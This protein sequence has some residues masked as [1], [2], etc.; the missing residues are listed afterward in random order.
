MR[1][2]LRVY[3][4]GLARSAS[5]DART[6]EVTLRLSDGTVSPLAL[7]RWLGPAD[8][9]DRHLLSTI[10][11]PVLDV[12]CGPGRHLHALAK[13]GVFALGIDLSPV[14]VEL[15]RDRGGN[16][17]VGSI[18][19][20]V[21]G[22]GTWRTALLLD[23]NI[24]IG[25]APVQLLTRVRALLSPAGALL[26]ELD[27][28]GADTGSLVA[29]I[30]RAAEVSSWFR[31]A[32]VAFGDIKPIAEAAGYSL[33]QRAHLGSRWFAR[34]GPVRAS[35]LA[36]AWDASAAQ[37]GHCNREDQPASVEKLLNEARGP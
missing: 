6:D 32:R 35:G 25:G 4:D 3:G 10:A 7:G 24:G 20:H 36:R 23:G 9:T 17:I 26:V 2:P 15:A 14:A 5:P 8:E 1:S 31:W 16:A 30:E 12:G 33:L 11:G 22:A 37:A 27:P 13:R 19:D 21:P 18:F 29:R 34:L 28:P